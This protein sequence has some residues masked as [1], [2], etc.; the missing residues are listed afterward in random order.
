MGK[1]DKRSNEDE[2]VSSRKRCKS[3]QDDD[4]SYMAIMNE[5]RN[6]IIELYKDHTCLWDLQVPNF[7]DRSAILSVKIAI[8]K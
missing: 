4:R 6:K 8:G 5:T 2:Y 1:R 7:M 3:K